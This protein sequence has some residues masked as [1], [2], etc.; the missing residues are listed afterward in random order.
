MGWSGLKSD[1]YI[2]DM[3]WCVF[4]RSDLMCKSR[5]KRSDAFWKSNACWNEMVEN[6]K[7]I[8][9]KIAIRIN[10]NSLEIDA[11]SIIRD[12]LSYKVTLKSYQQT[13]FA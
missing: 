2:Y 12:L 6:D 5:S 8:Q 7:S 9:A 3:I 1:I 4:A 11:E 13:N 10:I